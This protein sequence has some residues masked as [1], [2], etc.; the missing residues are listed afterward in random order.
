MSASTSSRST[1]VAKLEDPIPCTGP[2]T[3]EQAAE[4]S[5]QKSDAEHVFNLTSSEEVQRNTEK[6]DHTPEDEENLTFA[7]LEEHADL[8]KIEILYLRDPEELILKKNVILAYTDV[9]AGGR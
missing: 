1:S 8:E 6:K 3:P 4:V 2:G 9:N 7:A 5:D